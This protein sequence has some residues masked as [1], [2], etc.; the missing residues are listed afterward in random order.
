MIASQPRG[1]TELKVL[2]NNKLARSIK[3]TVG[4]DGRFD[5]GIAPQPTSSAATASLSPSRFSGIRTD[6]GNRAAWRT[7]AFYGHPLSGIHGPRRCSEGED[8]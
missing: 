5:N 4:A 3:F 7:E 6:R 1:V 8:R 2:W